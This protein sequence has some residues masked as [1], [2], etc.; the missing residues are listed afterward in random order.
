M[1]DDELG[2]ALEYMTAEIAKGRSDRTVAE[3]IR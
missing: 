2:I 1:Y 3:T